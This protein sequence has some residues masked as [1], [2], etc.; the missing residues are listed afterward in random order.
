MAPPPPAREI[1]DSEIIANSEINLA[2]NH[3]A[4]E[5][6]DDASGYLEDPRAQ[7][8]GPSDPWMRWR[9]SLHVEDALGRLALRGA[10]PRPLA[11]GDRE[12]A[13][14]PADARKLGSRARALR[15]GA[16]LMLEHL[17]DADAAIAA[18]LDTA[19]AI[20]YPA[21]EW[22]A[23]RLRAEAARRRGRGDRVAESED[24]IA[25]RVTT[26]ASTLP[27]DALRRAP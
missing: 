12:L 1:G 26:L 21:G 14:P 2:P 11:L 9:W 7:A 23:L 24:R 6:L 5:E 27:D 4:A 20:A 16:L 10:I 19:I 3:I 25:E 15:A 13:R 18:G 22:R 8:E 17:D